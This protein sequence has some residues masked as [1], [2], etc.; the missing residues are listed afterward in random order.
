M[1]VD[2]LCLYWCMY[3]SV[4]LSLPTVGSGGVCLMDLKI[5][6]PTNKRGRI[7]NILGR[8]TL[9]SNIEEVNLKF[10]ESAA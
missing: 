7:Q 3:M 8:T 5:K 4:I 2:F 1:E 10:L 6:E 9:H